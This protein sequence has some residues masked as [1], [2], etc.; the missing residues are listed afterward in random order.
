MRVIIVAAGRGSRMERLT[1]ARPKCLIEFDGRRLIDWQLAACSAASVD[2]VTIV[3]GYQAESL[4]AIGPDTRHNRDWADTNM[5]ASL[6]C[7]RDV[8][9]SGQDVLVAYSDI[10]YEPRLIEVLTGS[11][12]D[13]ETAVDLNWEALWKLRFEDPLSDA[14]TLR[15][16]DDGEILEIGQKPESIDEIEGQY[17]G[18]TR[19]SAKGATRLVGLYDD[20]TPAAAWLNGK[21]RENCYFTDILTG[22]IDDNASLVAAPVNGGW[23]EFDSGDDID[24]YT[25]LL[26]AGELGRF[27]SGE[28]AAA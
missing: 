8:L 10:I 13:I 28:K 19:F 9:L 16:G 18:L 27:W 14:E 5:V 4:R 2:D 15:L 25:S 3:T 7:A 17:I 26:E 21:S 12:S 23:L 24:A 11:R 20:A 6:M 22:L 1:E